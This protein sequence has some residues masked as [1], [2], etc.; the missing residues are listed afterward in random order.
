MQIKIFSKSLY[1]TCII[2]LLYLAVLEDRMLAV[3]VGL[4]C[5]YKVL[6]Q[7]ETLCKNH[8]NDHHFHRMPESIACSKNTNWQL[9][10]G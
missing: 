1:L 2:V 8:A 3:K 5:W 4:V 10:K 9:Y 7:H 6:G